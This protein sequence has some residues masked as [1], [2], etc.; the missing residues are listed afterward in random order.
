MEPPCNLFYLV[1]SQ[2]DVEIRQYLS[3]TRLLDQL[4]RKKY[5]IS[6]KNRF[7]DAHEGKLPI[8]LT[9]H[10]IPANKKWDAKDDELLARQKEKG[11]KFKELSHGYVSCWTKDTDENILMWKSYAPQAG[12]CICSTIYNFIA[13]FDADSFRKYDTYCAPVA[14]RTLNFTDDAEDALFVKQPYYKDEKEVRFLFLPKNQ[15]EKA[16]SKIWLPANHAVMI[17]KAILSPDI[18]FPAANSIKACLSKF[19]IKAELS[20]IKLNTN[21]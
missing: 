11:D 8:Q 9:F 19:G 21:K 2:P 15:E 5:Y 1:N 17:D 14:Y 4:V 20:K 10:P 3:L 7:E 16:D 6:Q 18:P 12:V 13:S